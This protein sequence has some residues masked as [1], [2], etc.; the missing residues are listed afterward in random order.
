MNAE[1]DTIKGSQFMVLIIAIVQGSVLLISFIDSIAKQDTWIVAFSSLAVSIPFIIS[2]IFLSKRF[3][4]KSLIQI[5]ELIYGRVLGKILSALYFLFFLMILSLNFRDV[6]DFFN[7]Y[8]MPETPQMI[9]LAVFALACAYAVKKGIRNIARLSFIT[10]VAGILIMVVTFMLLLG[11][12]DFTNFLP[13]MESSS[14][15]YIQSTHIFASVSFGEIIALMMVMQK[16]N[17]DKKKLTKYALLGMGISII[18]VLLIIIRN[19][20]VLGP[21]ASIDMESSYEAVRMI[22]IGGFLSRVELLIALAIITALFIKISI[23]YYA[24]V[25]SISQLLRLRS[26]SVLIIPIGSI[27]IILAT[28]GIDSVVFHNDYGSKYQQFVSLPFEFIF[29]PL[30]LFIAKIRK[31]RIENVQV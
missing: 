15:S 19:T 6:A 4:G 26:Y 1:K 7:G 3:P 18:Y 23:F 29:P 30:S 9:F 8:I 16:A 5:N 2:Y 14:K 11:I 17:D 27:A 21:S 25:V 12:M 22:N 24:T 10:V 31:L 20:A 28:I 13:M